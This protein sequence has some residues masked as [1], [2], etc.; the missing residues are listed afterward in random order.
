MY[1]K[2]WLNYEVIQFRCRLV[3]SVIVMFKSGAVKQ[4]VTEPS[5]QFSRHRRFPSRGEGRN[6]SEKKK[7]YYS[8]WLASFF[9]SLR[10]KRWLHVFILDSVKAALDTDR[11]SP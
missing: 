4:S 2:L 7:K 8:R 6:I 3:Q 5:I 10:A 9:S 11:R 1:E